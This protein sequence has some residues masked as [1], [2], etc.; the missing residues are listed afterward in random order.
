MRFIN[1]KTGVVAAVMAVIL[2]IS[3][4]AYAFWTTSGTGDGSATAGSA[5]NFTVTVTLAGGSYPGDG[6]T[7]AAVSGT[8]TNNTSSALEVHTISADTVGFGPTGVT[9]DSGHSGCLPA[10]FTFTGT[11]TG[12]TQTL[13]ASGGNAAYTGKLVMAESGINQDACKGATIT[14]HLKAA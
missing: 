3:G 6:P 10:D 8:I 14:L 2:A 9:F 4:I 1:K 13:A 5:G 7:G 11:V 12:G